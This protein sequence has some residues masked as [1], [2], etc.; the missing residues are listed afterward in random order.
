MATRRSEGALR[1]VIGFASAILGR[2]ECPGETARTAH[3]TWRR[4][5]PVA[6]RR[7]RSAGANAGD[8]AAAQPGRGPGKAADGRVP[9]GSTRGWFVE[10]QNL[11]IEYRWADG[12]YERLPELATELVRRK[13]D[14][15]ATGGGTN[16]AIAA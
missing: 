14:V 7:P 12:N 8:R 3:R 1:D 15:I 16:S 5:R 11:T 4:R 6:A 9:R 13:V 2:W 10:G